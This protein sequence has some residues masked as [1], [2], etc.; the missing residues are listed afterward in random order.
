MRL[1]STVL[2]RDG[3][4]YFLVTPV[5]RVGITVEDVP[6]SAV[7]MAVS[8]EGDNQVL[9]FRTQVDDWVTVD[10]DHPIRMTFDDTT[11]EPSPY[12]LVRARMEALICRPVF[13]DLVALG[14][15]REVD[16]ISHFGVLSS[17]TFFPF[18][19]SNEVSL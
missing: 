3:D 2:R 15:D 13:Y 5:E 18:A 9:K 7:E 16:G 6:F 8:G 10:T 1:F 11:K 12:V 17:G 14:E 19:P 4:D